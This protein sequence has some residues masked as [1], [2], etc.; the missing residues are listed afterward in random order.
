M[1][2]R[3]DLIQDPVQGVGDQQAGLASIRDPLR[4]AVR[5]RVAAIVVV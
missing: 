1:V 3:G 2:W 4:V 5:Y